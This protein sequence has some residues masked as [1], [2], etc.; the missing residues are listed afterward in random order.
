[1]LIKS[2]AWIRH[3][4]KAHDEPFQIGTSDISIFDFEL[5]GNQVYLIDTPGFNDTDRSDAETLR[6]LATYL[7]AS[8]SRNVFIHGI[9]YLHRIADNRMSGS[10]KRNIDMFKAL[11]GYSTYSNVAIATTF[12]NQQ[13]R[14]TFVQREAELKE[15]PA[16]FGGIVSEGARLFRHGEIGQGVQQLRDSAH[17]I[18]RHVV[19]QSRL[20]PVVLLIQHELVDERKALEQTAAGIVIAGEISKVAEGYK[21]QLATLQNDMKNEI[22]IQSRNQNAE[23]TNLEEEFQRK[24]TAAEREHRVLKSGMTELHEREQQALFDKLEATERRFQVRLQRREEELRDMKESLR[25]MREEATCQSSVNRHKVKQEL[26]EHETEVAGMQQSVQN[27]QRALNGFRST[28][29]SIG[30]GVV[31]GV[32][33]SVTTAVLTGGVYFHQQVIIGIALLTL[34]IQ[35]SVA[36]CVLFNRSLQRRVND[37]FGFAI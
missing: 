5:D 27:G 15:D 26:V 22:K 7:S 34:F 33:G 31:S 29:K 8:Y 4:K 9:I 23:I 13:E 16:F 28:I 14:R 17:A 10:S 19:A 18:V 1:M 37:A 36:F 20:A 2:S 11:C 12:W 30:Q 24:L 25:L 21:R 3:E 32:A 35:S 6:V